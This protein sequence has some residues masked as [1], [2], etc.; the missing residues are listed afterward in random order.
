MS[1]SKREWNVDTV[2]AS[3]EDFDYDSFAV[4]DED[5][6]VLVDALNSEV[7]S[8]EREGPDE[9]GYVDR[10]DEEARRNCTFIAASPA[11]AEALRRARDMLQSIAGDIEDGYSLAEMRGKY[12]LAVLGA[13]D[14]CDSALRLSR[15]EEPE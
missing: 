7:V 9:D 8:I 3:A 10:W 11:M 13:R 14:A 5:G 6:K 12:V 2:K 4:Y 1:K 15:G